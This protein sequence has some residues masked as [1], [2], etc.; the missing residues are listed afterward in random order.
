LR[1]KIISVGQLFSIL[2]INRLVISMTFGSFSVNGKDIWDCLLSSV[3]ILL[4]TFVLIIPVYKLCA[5]NSPLDICDISKF[6]LGKFGNIITIFYGI[7]FALVCAHTLAIF[8]VF[9]ENVM[10]PPISFVVL[11]T[12]MIIFSC[13]AASKGIEAIARSS[14]IILGFISIALVFLGFSLFKTIDFTNFKPFFYHEDS[15]LVDGTIFMLSRMSCIPIIGM[16]MSMVVGRV[17]NGIILW[18]IIVCFL[19]AVSIFFITGILGDLTTT[20]LFPFYTAA[21]VAKISKFE[22]LDAIYLGLWTA[23]VFIKL[24]ILLNLSSECIRKVLGKKNTKLI[25]IIFGTVLIITN[26]SVK[27]F[28][29]SSGVFNTKFLFII[30]ILASFV[31]PLFLLVC[32]KIS[33]KK[34]EEGKISQRSI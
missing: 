20:R 10:N 6:I 34:I 14:A 18:N 26:L 28:N 22:N 30:T 27:I 21:S 5:K 19:M 23:G 32:K 15:S 4:L 16:L 11:S 17:K 9:T 13:Y 12:S 24:S 2:V 29:I 25:I 3:L 1:S 8:K 31:I 7:Y 33:N